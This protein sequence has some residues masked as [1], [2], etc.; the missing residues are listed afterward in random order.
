MQRIAILLLAAVSLTACETLDDWFGSPDKTPRAQGE[1]IS[2]LSFDSQL[3]PDPQL[4]ETPVS[5]P[6][7]WRNPEWP[8]AGG[9]P[10][11]AMQHLELGDRL[12]TAWTG[13]LGAAADE[14]QKILAQPVIAGGRV[15]AMDAEALVSAFDAASGRR[16]WRVDLTPRKEDGG[17]TGGGDDVD[18]RSVGGEEEGNRGPAACPPERCTRRGQAEQAMRQVVQST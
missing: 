6:K 7:P 16:L 12:R 13:D 9:Y 2:V 3:D 4:Q 14:E 8:Q 15:F 1:R 18:V 11:H 10:S 17:A 5:L